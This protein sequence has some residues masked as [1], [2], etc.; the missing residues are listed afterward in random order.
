MEDFDVSLL[1]SSDRGEPNPEKSLK[2]VEMLIDI[3][4]TNKGLQA[5]V[6]AGEII[7]GQP[8]VVHDSS[9]RVI[10]MS[11]TML[12][13][14]PVIKL[15]DGNYYIDRNAVRHI[16][17][18]SAFEQSRNIDY[19]VYFKDHIDM[20]WLCSVIQLHGVDIAE[21]AMC[22]KNGK[23]SHVAVAFFNQLRKLVALELQKHSFFDTGSLVYNYFFEEL[24]SSGNMDEDLVS[25]RLELMDWPKL[26]YY[27]ILYIESKDK[28]RFADHL[29]MIMK[30]F[31][32]LLPEVR[33]IIRDEHIVAFLP[34]STPQLGSEKLNLIRAYLKKHD[35]IAGVSKSFTQ[36]TK[37]NQYYN[38]AVRSIEIGKKIATERT[39]YY[40]EDFMLYQI[41]SVI[42]DTCGLDEYISPIVRIV[43]EE[44]RQ[45][46]SELLKT[47]KYYLQHL[48]DPNTAAKILHIHRNTLFY[49][50]NHIKEISGDNLELGDTRMHVQFSIKMLEMEGEL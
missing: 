41:A 25:R 12:E 23:F 22:E 9:Y 15:E 46:G 7:T 13:G 42:A 49:R 30:E 16:T 44:D 40:Y 33:S 29:P 38:Q 11:R 19:P 45:K 17:S 8:I 36:L 48:G 21:M 18:S 35:L 34:L 31:Q 27:H 1:Y 10:A 5:L 47:L 26:G 39:T 2:N 37:S 50:I 4:Y 32:N 20:G 24:L 43:Q 6:N 3:L 28:N 14:G